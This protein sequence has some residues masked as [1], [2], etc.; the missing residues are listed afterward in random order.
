MSV[1]AN[2]SS[3]QRREVMHVIIVS[4]KKHVLFQ[5]FTVIFA[6]IAMVS[7]GTNIKLFFDAEQ[8]K[9]AYGAT[10]AIVVDLAHKLERVTIEKEKL[11]VT[12]QKKK[13]AAIAAS[14]ETDCLAK[15]IYFEAG[16]ESLAGK[17]AVGSVVV[18]RMKSGSF[19]RTACG[20][21]YQGASVPN[22]CQF[23]WACDGVNKAIAF[24]STAWRDSRQVAIAILSGN[25][26]A[27]D[28]TNGAMFFHNDSVK[29]SW[30]TT[31]R[32]TTQIGGHWFYK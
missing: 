15:N 3:V 24:G 11:D 21:V 4:R 25:K 28:N 30:A 17:Q 19:P 23:S 22:H 2:D 10:T 20:V 32:F 16:R 12:L 7:I 29:P 1:V 9:Q 18:N 8:Y 27:R 14:N 31:N 6:L 5:C 13:V 26:N